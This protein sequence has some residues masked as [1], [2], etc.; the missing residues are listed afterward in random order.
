M[1]ITL[2]QVVWTRS[3]DFC[4]YQEGRHYCLLHGEPVK[5]MDIS[6]CADWLDRSTTAAAQ[7]RAESRDAALK[8]HLEND[9]HNVT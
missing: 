8:N 7:L 2:S 3:C 6:R 1:S 9:E 4:S 5:N